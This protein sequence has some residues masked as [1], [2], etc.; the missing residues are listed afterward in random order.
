MSL[1]PSEL[2][3]GGALHRAGRLGSHCSS[4]HLLA[5]TRGLGPER[6]L[7]RRCAPAPVCLP[8]SRGLLAMSLLTQL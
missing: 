1:T 7:K 3:A 2:G 6:A 4:V 5:L 8:H